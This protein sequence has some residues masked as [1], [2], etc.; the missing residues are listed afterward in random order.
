MKNLKQALQDLQQIV[1]VKIKDYDIPVQI[2]NTIRIKHLIIRPCKKG[3][4]IIDTNNN[5]SIVTTYTKIA[6]MAIAKSY[7]KK[8]PLNSIINFDNQIEKNLND[9]VF[10]DNIIASTRD[11]EKLINLKI[12]KELAKEKV[13]IAKFNLNE[14]IV[15]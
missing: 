12:R 6:A 7:I 3:Y 11:S 15:S 2:G 5:K 1:D 14:Q 9:I 13:Y 10:Y 4:V 8:K